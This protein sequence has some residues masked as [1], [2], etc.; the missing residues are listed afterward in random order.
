MLQGLGPSGRVL[1]SVLLKFC[2][3]EPS[4]CDLQNAIRTTWKF[5]GSRSYV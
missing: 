3:Q 4:L 1:C 2:S 5:S